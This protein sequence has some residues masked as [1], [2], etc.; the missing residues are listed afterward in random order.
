MTVIQ[1]GVTS[2]QLMAVD[3]TFKA[4]RV[5]I[6]PPEV[7]SW[8]SVG[9]QSGAVTAVAANGPLF[10]FRYAG[11]NVCMIRRVGI[12]WATTTGFT[13]G[14]LVDF[15]LVIA[16]SFSASDSGGTAITLTGNNCK[17]RTSLATL[18]TNDC[19]IATTAALTAGTRTLDT[20]TLS[21]LSGFSTTATVGT[22]LG[23][24]LNNLFQHDAGDYPI[25][26]AN[27]E[28]FIITVLTAM[29]AAGVGRLYV[30]FEFAEATSF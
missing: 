4:G 11:S 7:L 10:S 30:N 22:F 17:H 25:V 24:G 28:G 13:A 15:G 21:Q 3:A 19:R 16:R 5:S 9:A 6:R 20:N 29:G 14:Q 18:T 12:G 26:L 23:T 27:N 2:S 8:G 1:D